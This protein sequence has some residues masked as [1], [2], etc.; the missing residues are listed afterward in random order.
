L[1]AA[2]TFP[3]ILEWKRRTGTAV[4]ALAWSDS[5]V[6]IGGVDGVLAAV[7][8]QDGVRVWQERGQGPLRT[9]L[10][11][12]GD[13]V[14]FLA[15]TW[16]RIVARAWDTGRLVWQRQ[17]LGWGD[18]RIEVVGRRVFVGSA[19]G[20][21]YALD[22]TDGSELWRVRTG[23]RVPHGF[24]LEK[25]KLWVCT[26]KGHLAEVDVRTG[27]HQRQ[28]DIA[29][30]VPAGPVVDGGS[31]VIST[32]DG[33][34]R[35][36]SLGDLEMRWE[37]R[38]GAMLEGVPRVVG[39]QVVGVAANGWVYGLDLKNGNMVWKY[40]LAA[41]PSGPLLIN[42][43]EEMIVATADGRLVALAPKGG[44]LLWEQALVPGK[45]LHLFGA[46][47][48]L[49]IGAADGFL[50]AF[51]R[52]STVKAAADALW[53]DWWESRDGGVKNGYARQ[54]AFR[55]SF[56]GRE[57][58]QIRDEAVAW[59]S[60]FL[61]TENE[62]W[63][64]AELR[65]LAFTRRRIEESQVV[66]IRG[67][68]QDG[69]VQIEERLGE[70]VRLHE[71]EVEPT[72]VFPEVA[73]QLL[74][75]QGRLREGRRDSLRVFDYGA[76]TT[77]LLRVD[78]KVELGADVKEGLG[79]VVKVELGVVAKHE[80][81]DTLLRVDMSYQG[82]FYK[83]VVFSEWLDSK[84]RSV[85]AQVPALGITETRVEAAQA[86]AWVPPGAG[87][88]I[89]LDYAVEDPASVERL[90][91]EL[92]VGIEQMRHFFIEDERQQLLS[93]A[94][95]STRLVIER[96]VYGSEAARLPLA[97]AA[98]MPFLESSLYVQADDPRI[99]SLARQLVGNE[100]DAWKVVQRL[101]QW[102]Y[103]HMV[104]KDTNVRFKSSLE[105][106]Q[107]MEGTCS[108]YAVLF[109]ALCRAAGVPVRA[110]VGFVAAPA[111]ALTLHIWTQ[112]YVGQWVDVDPSWEGL[113]VDAAHIKTGQGRLTPAGMQALNLPL[114][115]FL[116]QAD[117]LK[118]V[119]YKSGD[120]LFLA[121]AE[122]LFKEAE[123]AERQFTEE[124]AQELYH[125]IIL[126][127][128]NRR[129]GEAYVR[130]GR[131]RVQRQ[132]WEEAEWAL[133]R[134]L[135]LDA[136]GQAAAQALFYLSRSAEGQGRPQEAV[137]HLEVLIAQYPAHDLADDALGRLG[138]LYERAEGC[139]R[140]RPFYRR[141]REEYRAS[142][143]AGVAESALERCARRQAALEDQ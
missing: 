36:Y 54:S 10:Q 37:R 100:G 74:W 50:Y 46:Q 5:L 79:A 44:A 28:V 120:R 113:V 3:Y 88:T 111:E 140:A 2:N 42:R 126:L 34:L 19:D 78:V 131:F 9:R 58:L 64:D 6:F 51:Q 20:W 92:P 112:V 80:P 17:G 130:I 108:E 136:S 76:F 22:A 21:L 8:R 102:V 143:W 125:Q 75:R 18:A 122:A 32:Q 142:G 110:C 115:R 89:H 38:L 27:A 99:Q 139:K 82:P 13:R 7:R 114:Q 43:H 53:D 96:Q 62:L 135:R 57:A 14:I 81:V 85:R 52:A 33:Y 4:K 87:K 61:R 29:A 104:P 47:D 49:Y 98:L 118:V 129:S 60:G 11:L 77:R 101:A 15:D 12:G 56:Q 119:E 45:A 72:A 90:V 86:L 97:G 141:L 70:Q 121:A 124:R 63:V 71:V 84:G 31:V 117:T 83:G 94:E 25:D 103:D 116:V 30:L 73:L 95:G 105:V 66:E 68:W 41:K 23:W 65:P 91:L 16:G 55:R 127:P 59:R 107:D 137:A 132:Q 106:L 69:T 128:W 24:W 39:G 40:D 109:M 67:V 134:Q 26:S 133:R 35:A 123:E 138:E 48:V 1:A 93:N